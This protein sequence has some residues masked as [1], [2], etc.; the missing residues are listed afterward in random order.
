MYL[1]LR[2]K[3]RPAALRQLQANSCG[4]SGAITPTSSAH[5]TP[6]GHRGER[7]HRSRSPG[8]RRSGQ[9]PAG[10][11]RRR[12]GHSK[13]PRP[14]HHEN[15]REEPRHSR[16]DERDEDPREGPPQQEPTRRA[17]V[18]SGPSFLPQVHIIVF[19]ANHHNLR[20]DF[21]NPNQ[22]PEP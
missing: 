6:R 4:S 2:V 13:I 8:A 9:D 15:P 7:G 16:D 17:Q 1:R 19:G 5:S 14:R 20:R 18:T 22:E 12:R 10:T 3:I 21:R 11:A